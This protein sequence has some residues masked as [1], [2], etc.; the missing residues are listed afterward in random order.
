[1]SVR[2]TKALRQTDLKYTKRLRTILNVNFS[3]EILFLLL[4]LEDETII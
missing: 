4:I 1:M 3:P 2:E